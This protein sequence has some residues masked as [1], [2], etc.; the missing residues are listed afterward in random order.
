MNPE[1]SITHELADGRGMAHL[2][3]RMGDCPIAEESSR[4]GQECCPQALEG[5]YLALEGVF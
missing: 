2:A 4:R 1:R 3:M 5:V